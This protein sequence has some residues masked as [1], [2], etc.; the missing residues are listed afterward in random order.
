[1]CSRSRL[2]LACLSRALAYD[3]LRG[4]VHAISRFRHSPLYDKPSYIDEHVWQVFSG[5]AFDLF[6]VFGIDVLQ[7]ETSPFRQVSPTSTTNDAR[8]LTAIKA[9]TFLLKLV[10]SVSE[11][12][13]ATD[14]KDHVY[15]MLGITGLDVTPDYS[16]STPTHV[17]FVDYISAALNNAA[18]EQETSGLFLGRAG[19]GLFDYPHEF[20]TWVP[21]YPVLSSTLLLP[22]IK[23]GLEMSGSAAQYPRVI[24]MHLHAHFMSGTRQSSASACWLSSWA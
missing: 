23:N 20:P 6:L 4:A 12:K 24:G 3:A 22:N 14:P 2:L 5:S 17:A 11:Y 7:T 1:M 9:D 18:R 16:P 19:I 8:S 21:N 15:G 13:Q 10:G